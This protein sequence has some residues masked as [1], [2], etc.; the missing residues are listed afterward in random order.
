[1]STKVCSDT[2]LDAHIAPHFQTLSHAFTMASSKIPTASQIDSVDVDVDVLSESVDFDSLIKSVK[3]LSPS[4]WIKLLKST[5]TDM[6]KKLKTLSTSKTGRT[7]KTGSAPKGETPKQLR[8]THAW[9]KYTLQHALKN[10]WPSFP[11]ENKKTNEIIDMPAS[12]THDGAYVYEDSVT[13]DNPNGKQIIHKDAMSLSKY[14]KTNVP[15]VYHEFET[16]FE[17]EQETPNSEDDEKVDSKPVVKMTAAQKAEE[18][19]AAAEAKKAQAELDK[20]EKAAQKKAQ[21]EAKKQSEA[22]AKAEAAEAKK[23]AKEQEKAEKAKNSPK[24]AVKSPV[25]AAA[26][27]SPTSSSSSSSSSSA[28]SASSSSSASIS[29]KKVTAP[30]KLTKPDSK[31]D[32]EPAWECPQDDGVYPWT[33]KT[34]GG[35]EYFRNFQN[36]V[37]EK[38]VDGGLGKWVGVYDPTTN[39]MDTDAPEPVFEDE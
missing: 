17:Q 20:A 10:G 34:G 15:E 30:K 26:V 38:G 3:A 28:S 12:T 7:K 29:I 27:S 13:D 6:D 24:K 37:W 33:W 23:A 39:K 11:V 19:K 8:K 35:K 21:Q 18:R 16:V 36:E 2:A 14:Y 9:V 22:A 32:A 25:K 5:A 31:T 4:D 1:M